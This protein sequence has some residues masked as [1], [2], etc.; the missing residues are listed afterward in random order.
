M[1]LTLGATGWGFDLGKWAWGLIAGAISGAAGTV[2][3]T[4]V[5][6]G[7]DP[8][9]FNSIMEPGPHTLK[10]MGVLFMYGMA[11]NMLTYMATNQIPSPFRESNTSTLEQSKA[12]I[13]KLSETSTREYLPKGGADEPTIS[14]PALPTIVKKPKKGK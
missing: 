2:I 10:L 11:K 3:L 13:V 6:A 14:V 1:M 12:G 8:E 4:P 5:I 7:I 9:H